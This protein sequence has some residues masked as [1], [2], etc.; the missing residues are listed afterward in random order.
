MAEVLFVCLFLTSFNVFTYPKRHRQIED[1]LKRDSGAAIWGYRS[2]NTPSFLAFKA[3]QLCSWGLLKV[4][5]FDKHPFPHTL[6][7]VA[8]RPFLSS[9]ASPLPYFFLPHCP[10]YL[11]ETCLLL[12]EQ[13][14]QPHSSQ[15]CEEWLYTELDSAMDGSS[16]RQFPHPCTC[17]WTGRAY[18]GRMAGMTTQCWG[19]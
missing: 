17:S 1:F 2:S 19:T 12:Q 7:F 4:L 15:G 9:A 14:G 6:H 3:G 16:S 10:L 8:L 18:L 11:M 5:T 13:L